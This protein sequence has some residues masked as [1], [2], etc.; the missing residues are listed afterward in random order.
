MDDLSGYYLSDNP[1]PEIPVIDPFVSDIRRN[2]EIF[3]AKIFR[4]EIEGLVSK[5][6]QG[7]NVIYLAGIQFDKG[8]GKSALMINHM[9]SLRKSEGATCAYVKCGE[10]DKPRDAARKIVE[11]WHL[12]GYLWESFKTAFTEFS[13]AKRDPF[14]AP[15][16]VAALFKAN[17]GLPSRLPLNLYTRVRDSWKIAESFSAWASTK[18]GV[19]AE[20]LVVFSSDYLT[21]PSDFPESIKKK[22]VDVMQVYEACSK[23]LVSFGY[24]R[25]YVFMDQFEDMVMGTTKAGIG[26]FAL[27]V[28]GLIKASSGTTTIFVTLHPN[29]ETMLNVPAAQDMTGLAPLDAVH[30][31]NVMVL[32]VKGNSAIGLAE[33]YFRRFRV[34]EPPYVTYPVEPALLEFTCYLKQG[35]IRDFLLQLHNALEYGAMNGFPELTM[36]YAFKN[37]LDVLGRD[38]SKKDIE[39]YH[40]YK[41]EPVA[42]EPTGRSWGGAVKGFKE[43]NKLQ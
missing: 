3:H 5:T 43:T 30:R 27:E 18:V 16:A 40:R 33:E 7:L 2:G 37:P 24:K 23:F 42:P 22:S 19:K 32:D 13:V 25:H 20:D 12:S 11:Q 15:D 39:G 9:R 29:S 36:D 26:K 35:R 4:K 8:I 10:R 31:I 34:G 14:L 6:A 28:K 38:V 41:G 17:S 1:F 21:T